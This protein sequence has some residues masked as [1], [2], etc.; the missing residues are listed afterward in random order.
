MGQ[1]MPSVRYRK[2]KLALWLYMYSVH[3]PQCK[4][5]RELH[6]QVHKQETVGG[7]TRLCAWLSQRAQ[8]MAK[9]IWAVLHV[10]S[11]QLLVLQVSMRWTADM[12]CRAS[13]CATSALV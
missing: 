3:L 10:R 2:L 4:M 12:G 11:F 9:D 6:A 7:K 5:K 8:E 13:M 1:I